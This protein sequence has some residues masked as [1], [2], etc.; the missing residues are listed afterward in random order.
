MRKTILQSYA[1][2]QHRLFDLSP[3]LHTDI[4]DT[5]DKRV[6]I[7]VY[8]Q[9]VGVLLGEEEEV[10][11]EFVVRG[12]DGVELQTSSATASHRGY[13]GPRMS[14]SLHHRSGCPANK[15]GTYSNLL[16]AM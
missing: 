5:I 3:Y 9:V 11:G 2:N 4:G 1:I 7:Y 15:S 10:M 12:Q 16:N 8:E 14:L 6:G 13:P